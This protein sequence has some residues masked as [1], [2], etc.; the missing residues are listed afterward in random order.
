MARAGGEQGAARGVRP[1]R[2]RRASAALPGAAEADGR[3]GPDAADARRGRG[4]RAQTLGDERQFFT[5]ADTVEDLE[6]LRIALG[7]DKLALDGISYGTFVAQRYALAYPD[8]V[9][10]LVLDSVVPAEGVS[11]LSEVSIKATRRV[12][13]KATTEDLAKVVR[14]QHNGPQ[15][16]DMLTA[17]S[18][19]AP[20]GDGAANAIA[21]GRRR[22]R[23]GPLDGC[24]HAASRTWCTAGRRR[25]SARACTRARC[26]RTRR[27]RG[28]TR[29]RPLEGRQAALDAAAAKLSDD[30]LYPYDRATATGNG[31]ALQCLNWPPVRRAR[32]RAPPRDLPDVPTLLLAGDR[33]LS[34]PMEWAQQAAKR[35]PAG[36]LIIVKGAGHDVQ[37]QGDP[38]ALAAVRRLV[39]SPG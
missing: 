1:A 7:A 9:S 36:R 32:V 26:A 16:L 12:L 25:S 23:S 10:G 14:E 6:A 39:A 19:G 4:L 29:R 3:L 22:R 28:A 13:G 34:T 31:I 21:R 37:D 2:H 5:T 17:L 27:R 15:M 18:V 30:D 38:E 24:L 33:D 11:L 20:R 35:A 8:R